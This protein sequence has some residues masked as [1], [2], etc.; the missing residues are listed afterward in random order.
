[1]K[2]S[3]KQDLLVLCR[4]LKILRNSTHFRRRKLT[5]QLYIYKKTVGFSIIL[6]VLIIFTT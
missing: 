6:I 4:S 1:M 2:A 5:Y 3:Q